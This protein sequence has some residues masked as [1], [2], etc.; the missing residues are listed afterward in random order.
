MSLFKRLLRLNIAM[1]IFV[2]SAL[3]EVPE[4]LRN[5]VLTGDLNGRAGVDFRS[6]ANNV[7][8]LVPKG[9]K[10][11]V[12]EVR[13]LKKTGSYGIKMKVTEAVVRPGAKNAVKKDQEVWVYYSQKSPWLDFRDVNK[14]AIQ[15]PE[16]ALTAQAKR[17][18]EALPALP[19]TVKNPSLP[20]EAEVL[21]NS[22]DP[23]SIDPNEAM[24]DRNQTQGD[25]CPN[26]PCTQPQSFNEKN[27][28][29]VE[30]VMKMV[31][32]QAS[33]VEKKKEPAPEK[34]PAKEVAKVSK[35]QPK[36]TPD[37]SR[38]P[39]TEASNVTSLY[40]NDPVVM[41]YSESA[42]TKKALRFAMANKR[43]RSGGKCYR[44]VKRALVASKQVK[45]YPPGGHA[46]D[47][48]KDLKAQGWINLLDDPRYKGK[49]KNPSDAPKGAVVVTWNSVLRES[50]DINMKL[51]W[52]DK[53]GYV[54]DF[55]NDRP[56]KDGPKGRRYAKKGQPYLMTGVMIKP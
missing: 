12:L 34:K 48:V 6:N 40:A 32:P 15:D 28:Q 54:S 3:A 30:A 16:Q 21:K 50:G 2:S 25:W 33:A 11:E 47:A 8:S 42:E 31:P 1:L 55:Y 13:K 27:I 22:V 10:G 26:V 35:D 37:V 5:F 29:E 45:T 44:Y 19:G 23:D 56:M 14:E 49:I 53:G 18:G 39:R 41:K 46:R 4:E 52:G 51:D 20:T 36:A 38:A 24:P 7:T 9:T 43:S 17:D